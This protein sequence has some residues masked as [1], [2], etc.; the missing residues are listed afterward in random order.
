MTTP[1]KPPPVIRAVAPKYTVVGTK[2][3]DQHPRKKVLYWGDPFT[4]KTNYAKSFPSPFFIYF[5]PDSTTLLSHPTEIPYVVV[6]SKA[7]MDALAADVRNRRM[8]EVVRGFGPQWANYTVQ[9]VV[10]DS[11]TF[12]D[13]LVEE[14]LDDNENRGQNRWDLKSRAMH[15]F[16]GDVCAGST[17]RDGAEQ[18]YIVVTAHEAIKR[19]KDG[20][21]T[22]I[23][24]CI[25]GNFRK[26]IIQYMDTVIFCGVQV[27]AGKDGVAI[28]AAQYVCRT[29]PPDKFRKCGARGLTKLPA[30]LNEGAFFNVLEAYWNAA[31][32]EK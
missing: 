2:A 11:S 19:D 32:K 20:N 9:T 27:P 28:G 12:Q 21:I 23:T 18:Y 4:G 1:L 30:T 7:V 22:E 10:V 8:T 16:Y 13:K 15:G 26:D 31:T 3:A 5:D 6:Q 25:S 24:T 17:H 29:Q 14:W